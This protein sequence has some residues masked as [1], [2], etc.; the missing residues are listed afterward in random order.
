MSNRVIG[1]SMRKVKTFEG[2]RR[3]YDTEKS[4]EVAKRAIGEFGDSAG[5]EEILYQTK[6]GL[7]FVVGLGGADSPYPSEDIKPLT[8]SEAA[9]F[10]A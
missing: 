10:E 5:Y 6:Q 1:Y 7:Y 3:T 2:K 4:T 9:D 8:K